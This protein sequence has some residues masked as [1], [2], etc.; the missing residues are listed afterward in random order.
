[1]QPMAERFSTSKVT[2]TTIYLIRHGQKHTV[3]GDPGLTEIGVKQAQETGK[4]LQQFPISKVIASPFKRTIE[5]AQ[6]ISDQL[7]IVHSLH[8][9]LVERMNWNDP[10]VTRQQ[11]LQEW[12]KST[13]NR[14]YTPKYGYS[15]FA[16][17]QRIQ[18][19]VSEFS[20]PSEHLVL[21]THGGAII[22]YLRNIFGDDQLEPLRKTYAEG[23]DYEML[24]CS[25]NRVVLP[26]TDLSETAS[27]TLDLLNFVEH[28]SDTSE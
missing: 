27:A 24:N 14:E 16:T 25:I 4:Y 18:K 8:D 1:M 10:S 15:S 11:F 3:A 12:V 9:A 13:N 17:G 6:H 7:G 23:D 5:T 22:D 28:L 21:V 26:T 19:V 2:M 20:N